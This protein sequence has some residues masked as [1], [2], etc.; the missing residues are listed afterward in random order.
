M[1]V[2]AAD[3]GYKPTTPQ[4]TSTQQSQRPP[5]VI[6]FEQQLNRLSTLTDD[7]RAEILR[8]YNNDPTLTELWLGNNNISKKLEN[9]ID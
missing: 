4:R 6:P 5:Q 7:A 2:N 3:G 9:Q 8:V 1:K